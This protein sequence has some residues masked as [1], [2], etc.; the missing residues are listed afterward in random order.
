MSPFGL[1]EI[2]LKDFEVFSG[3]LLM[4]P[5]MDHML[6]WPNFYTKD[7]YIFLQMGL[8]RSQRN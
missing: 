1:G 7:T 5:N 3:S 8:G 4:K 2:T 6:T